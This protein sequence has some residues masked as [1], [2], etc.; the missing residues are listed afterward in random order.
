[1][2]G[3]VE[4]LASGMDEPILAAWSSEDRQE[5]V[6]RMRERLAARFGA[7]ARGLWLTERVWEPDLPVDLARAGI[8]YVVV[9]DRH[10]LAAG[11]EREALHLPWRTEAAGAGITVLPIDERLRYLVP[12]R[13]V[14][15]FAAYLRGLRARGLRLALLADDGE[16]FGGWPGTREWVYERGWLAAYLGT[17]A[18]L[19][20]AGEVELVTCGEAAARLPSAGLV[21][22]PSGSYREME[23]WALPAPAA[24]R[25]AALEADLGERLDGPDG[26]LVRGTHWR[27]FLAKYPEAN[28]MH[29][30]AM[31]LSRLAR[32]RG[33]GPDVRHA[34]G[35][36]QC[37]DAYWH[38]VFGGLYL[39][40]L[41]ATV[42]SNLAA[43]EGLLRAGEPL[44]VELEDVDL[45]GHDEV[46]VHGAAFAA[47]VSPARGGGVEE[48][49]LFAPGVN[50]ADVLTRRR[51][52]Y[53]F[54]TPETPGGAAAPARD[55]T[56]SIH[57]IEK[58]LSLDVLPP[59]D[60]A[61]RAL[62]L[63]RLLH[64]PPDPEA[65][66]AGDLPVARSWAQEPFAVA[67]E[68]HA[69]VVHVRL[70]ASGLEKC[71]SFHQDGTL[72]A[73]LVWTP[74]APGSWFTTEIS[75]SRPLLLD[76]DA[77]AVRRHPIETV[78]KSERGLERTV[79][80]E[81]VVAGWPADSGR[82][83]VRVR[84]DVPG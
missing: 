5:Q 78:A 41:R 56:P 29:K 18:A 17:L 38:G 6:V 60:S 1:A 70:A 13:P 14:D 7:D 25:L 30:K 32:E 36:A 80:G 76:T 4:L 84:V 39:P 75:T 62:F 82:G 15:E 21:Y 65:L 66:A 77:A 27:S 49:T 20:D 68:R 22:L 74:G 83:Y 64:A 16:K 55:G 47:I 9:D 42:W 69:D 45:D 81:A 34:I 28:R 61:P 48:L 71:L 63:E 51:E 57:A 52:A 40:F 53:H 12:F 44:G 26:A 8:R 23:G 31:R 73:A 46:S 2:D 33:A 10:F 58:Q 35:R 59:V 43:A 72:S 50:L 37:N 24:R 11:L 3:R 19:R 67:L 54:A 79:Q